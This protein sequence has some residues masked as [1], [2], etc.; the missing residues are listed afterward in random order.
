MKGR[1]EKI[2]SGSICYEICINDRV[3]I[4]YD[5]CGYDNSRLKF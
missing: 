5:N 2:I 3:F 4:A 1:E